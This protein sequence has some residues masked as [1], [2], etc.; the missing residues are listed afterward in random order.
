MERHKVFRSDRLKV[1]ENILANEII[2]QRVLEIGAGDYSFNYLEGSK[3]WIKI[4]FSPPCDV[5]F[6]FNIQKLN[7]PF[8]S[9]SFDLIIC[10]QVLEHLLWPQQLLKECHRILAS[11][12]RILIS[13][14][15]VVS[16]TYRIA[17]L[18]GRIPSCA[19]SGNL[20]VEL[21]STSY[22]NKEGSLV[23]GHVI[24]F[25]NKRTFRLLESCN[26]KILTVKGS[27]IIWKKQII[28]HQLVPSN[29]SSD[30]ICLAEKA[31]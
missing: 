6:D 25:N 19:A 2:G 8:I 5:I 15:N 31:V 21:G 7:L 20:P 30:I 22:R 27:G 3:L 12:G 13:V 18:L 9:G 17:W 26:F 29:L 16:L 28:P 23:G 24:D 1:T 10:T 11:N 14:P 4:D